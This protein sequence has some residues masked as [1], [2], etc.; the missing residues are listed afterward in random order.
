MRIACPYCGERDSR[1]FA[2]R[3]EAFARP[4]HGAP[5]A[6]MFDAVYL[7]AN[8]AGPNREFWYHAY[9]CRS[10]LVVERDTRTHAILAVALA[11][12]GDGDA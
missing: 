1:E 9:G 7:R 11:K 10:W 2:V 3:G 6:A 4:E 8:P 5:E 12:R